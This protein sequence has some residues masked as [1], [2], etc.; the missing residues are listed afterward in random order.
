MKTMIKK[1]CKRL[2]FKGDVVFSASKDFGTIDIIK[3]VNQRVIDFDY[4]IE[5]AVENAIKDGFSAII[6]YLE[7]PSYYQK[8]KDLSNKR[9]V[10]KEGEIIYV[11]KSIGYC[12][13]YSKAAVE[14]L[15]DLLTTLNAK[16]TPEQSEK[17]INY[18]KSIVF[19]KDGTRRQSKTNFLLNKDYEVSVLKKFKEF[20]WTGVYLEY[21]WNG[22]VA[23]SAPI[24]RVIAKN[25]DY[26]E[27]IASSFGGCRLY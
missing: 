2:G 3:S 10:W 6:F 23:N 7:T 26:F 24:Y 1:M 17:G 9:K 16:I 25:G 20:R 27:Y 12:S 22:R 4:D 15:C 11:R 14:H 21:G 19:R 8:V 5:C 18:L 13:S